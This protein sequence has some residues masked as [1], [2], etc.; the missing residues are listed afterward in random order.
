MKI[1]WDSVSD[2]F[3]NVARFIGSL[4]CGLVTK[5]SLY[6]MLAISKL[7]YVAAFLPPSRDILKVEKRALQLVLRGPWNAI[8]DGVF[9]NL[10]SIGFPV[11]ARDLSTLSSASRVRVASSTSR[12]VKD[13]YDKS[14][15]CDHLL[16]HSNEIVL[17]HLD[18]HF[19]HQSCLH[20]VIFQHKRFEQEFPQF[21]GEKLQTSQDR[22]Q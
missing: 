3:L 11:Q 8:P 4:D 13:H 7:S 15:K 10:K 9:Q 17:H 20:H 6:N 22:S 21:V 2:D 18:F 12:A 16:R 14:H 1:N 5:V 19:L